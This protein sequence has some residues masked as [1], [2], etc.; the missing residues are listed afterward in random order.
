M[1]LPITIAKAVASPLYKGTLLVLL[2]SEGY[3]I[4][5]VVRLSFS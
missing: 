5:I 2:I 3:K 4:T 1:N